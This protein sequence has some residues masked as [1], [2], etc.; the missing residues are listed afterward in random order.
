VGDRGRKPK[1]AY[2]LGS[3]ETIMAAVGQTKAG[4][5]RPMEEALALSNRWSAY[6]KVFH[7][8]GAPGVDG[9]TVRSFKA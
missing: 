4:M 2:S 3:A 8:G 7:T 9:L 1:D 5:L 6:Q